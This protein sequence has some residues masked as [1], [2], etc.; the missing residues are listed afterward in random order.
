MVEIIILLYILLSG[1]LIAFIYRPTRR[2]WLLKWLIVSALPIVGWLFPTVWANTNSQT[3]EAGLEKDI[4][5]L[6]D[7]PDIRQT[8]I[9]LRIDADKELNVVSIEEALVVSRHSDRRSVMINVLKQDS[10]KYMDVLQ[11]AVSNED[12]ETS[13]YAVSA[14]MELKRK[15]TLSLQ[16]LSVQYESNKD[17]VH[18]LRTYANVIKAYMQSGF[19]DDRTLRKYKFTYITV[20]GNLIALSPESDSVYVEKAEAELDVERLTEAENTSLLYLE[21]YPNHEE[22][23]LSLLKVYFNMKSYEK[24][25]ETLDL[26]KSSPLRLSNRALTLVRFW[27]EGA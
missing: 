14:V 19:L 12:S 23:Y 9:H 6:E 4:F 7:E 22:A 24:M 2:E 5:E 20:L 27:S 25:K 11:Q 17:D 15:L 26:L 1:F 13:H 8:G 16:E 18:V 10:L 3:K 21:R